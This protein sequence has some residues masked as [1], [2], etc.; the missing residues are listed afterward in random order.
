MSEPEE[1]NA[2][3]EAEP[4]KWYL[5]IDEDSL[6]GPVVAEKLREWAQQGRVAPGNEVSADR[7]QW[8][9]AEDLPELEMVWNV[10]LDDGTFFGP[11]NVKALRDLLEDETITFDSRLVN[12]TSGE[13]ASVGEM[14]ADIYAEEREAVVAAAL[15][16]QQRENTEVLRRIQ[17]KLRGSFERLDEARRTAEEEKRLHAQTHEALSQRDEVIAARDAQIHELQAQ[18]TAEQKRIADMEA[19]G[20]HST[21][22]LAGELESLRSECARVTGEAEEVRAQ[23]EGEQK[24]HAETRQSVDG[25]QQ[26][27]GAAN[28]Q[29]AEAQS[30]L[31]HAAAQLAD[32]QSAHEGTRK[33]LTDLRQALD[34]A[35]TGNAEHQ[36][37]LQHLQS[38]LAKERTQHADTTRKRDEFSRELEGERETLAS[39]RTDLELKNAEL[40]ETTAKMLELE[41]SLLETRSESDTALEESLQREQDLTRK[42]VT[43]QQESAENARSLTDV[44]QQLAEAAA[45]ASS[46]KT[47][48][49]Q[50]DQERR[51]NDDLGKIRETLEQELLTVKGNYEAELETNRNRIEQL[52][53]RTDGSSPELVIPEIVQ[54]ESVPEPPKQTSSALVDLEAQAQRELRAWQNSRRRKR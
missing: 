16:E 5:R 3:Q 18:L 24:T 1:Q 13:T 6:Y 39:T 46:V 37:R 4:V 44:Q 43:V 15:A 36:D 51:R 23:L 14:E 45:V 41:G 26:E 47:L 52:L 10:E 29:C 27:L 50:L 34:S 2:T 20:R 35:K 12:R 53:A 40:A 48:E 31:E 33:T 28:A 11:L 30:Q 25:V 7:E 32:E 8:I 21:E 38:E 19:Q 17:S 22:T 42:L 49:K 54:E 9:P